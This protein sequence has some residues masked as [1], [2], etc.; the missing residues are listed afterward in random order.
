M[1]LSSAEY[2]SIYVSL[3]ILALPLCAF[4]IQ[5]IIPQKSAVLGSYFSIVLLLVMTVLSIQVAYWNWTS[6]TVANIDWFEIGQSKIQ[7]GLLLNRW[8][9]VMLVIVSFISLLV[10]I[11]S[12]EYMKS[13]SGYKRY[14]AALSLFT[15]AMIGIV[16][17][18]SLLVIF[19]FWELVGFCSYLLIGHWFV[20][21]SAASAS[22]KAFIV[23]R[24][25]DLGFVIALALCW[26]NFETFSISEI[27]IIYSEIINGSFTAAIPS[28]TLTVIGITFFIAAIGKSAQFPLQVWLPDAME[29]PTPV[30]ALIHAAT[31]VAAGVYLLSRVVFLLDID[32]LTFIAIV[33][34]I[35]AFMGAFAAMKQNDVKKVLAF[36][37]VS[38]LGYMVVGIGVGAYESALLHL[39]T[40]AFFKAGLFLGAGT[41]IHYLHQAN[42]D[43]E[44]DAQDMRLMGGLRK[45]LPITFYTYTIFS[46]SLIGLPM[47]SGFLS[48]EAILISAFQMMQAQE[49]V[50]YLVV[51]LAFATVAMTAFYVVRQLLLLFAGDYRGENENA[52]RENSLLIKGTLVTLAICSIGFVWSANPLDVEAVWLTAN[53]PIVLSFIDA[54]SFDSLSSSTIHFIT[55]ISL[56]LIVAGS[57]LAW[58]F[59][60][61]SVI[62]QK[63]TDEI[64]QTSS[65]TAKLSVNNWYLDSIYNRVFVA[66]TIYFSNLLAKFERQVIDRL[67][68]LSGLVTVV[69]AHIIGWIDRALIDGVVNTS[70]YVVGRTGMVT[71]SVHGNKIQSYII[72]AVIGVLIILFL[73]L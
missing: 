69:V 32:A 47:F 2:S 10:T 7:V 67:V 24:I 68:N 41:I 17:S 36:S 28:F 52:V 44:Y 5:S 45:K 1:E 19:I 31:M 34:S 71:K 49:G 6:I 15:F 25:G 29:G 54:S 55:L 23:N 40:H 53:Y 22:K 39:F 56:A 16:L 21:D 50:F 60:K 38:Q 27:Q 57:F 70:A 48:K 14:F 11:F 43:S 9:G 8:A 30:S 63:R 18:D 72:W 33:G 13:D 3:L 73:A 61:P 42:N 4:L 65:F 64:S 35:T 37:T 26:S 12:L 59:Y 20:K 46:L 66:P 62:R 58:V 51:I